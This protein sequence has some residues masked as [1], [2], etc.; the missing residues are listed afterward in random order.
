MTTVR[1][2]QTHTHARLENDYCTT[3]TDTYTRTTGERLL[4]D[5]N[6]H[7]RLENDYC[8]ITIRLAQTQT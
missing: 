1:R 5:V 2:A 3:C 4:Y 6:A 7:A 8:T